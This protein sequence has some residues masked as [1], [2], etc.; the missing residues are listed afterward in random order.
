MSLED[1]D[2]LACLDPRVLKAHWVFLGLMARQD[3]EDQKDPKVL[4]V[5]Q[6]TWDCL[7]NKGLR[8]KQDPKAILEQALRMV[9]KVTL[10]PEV[11]FS[12]LLV[13]LV[14]LDLQDPQVL[15]ACQETMEKMDPKANPETL[16]YLILI[17]MLI[18]SLDLLDLRVL[19]VLKDL[20]ANVDDVE[21]EAVPAKL[22]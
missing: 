4:R 8:A 20:P 15:L 1:L 11:L 14:C 3:L 12:R 9:C 7:V 22:P 5:L 16:L 6:A 17:R 2:L 13:H 21:R 18:W 10:V 19:L